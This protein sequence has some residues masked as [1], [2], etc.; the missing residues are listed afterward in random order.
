MSS[1]Q[2]PHLELA[3]KQEVFDEGNCARRSLRSAT[4]SRR[5]R[6]EDTAPNQMLLAATPRR[7]LQPHCH[8]SID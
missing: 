1:G 8:R 3:L 5:D 2:T 6:K 4:A 7:R